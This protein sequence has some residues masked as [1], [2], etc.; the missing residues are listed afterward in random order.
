[1]AEPTKATLSPQWRPPH[2]NRKKAE[3]Q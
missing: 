1:M 3:Y 2:P